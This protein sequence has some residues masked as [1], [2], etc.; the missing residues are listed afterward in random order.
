MTAATISAILGHLSQ[1]PEFVR[2][3]E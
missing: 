2:I 3:D 1:P